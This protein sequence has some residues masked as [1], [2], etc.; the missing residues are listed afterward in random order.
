MA[1]RATWRAGEPVSTL[2]ELQADLGGALLGGPAGAAAAVVLEHGLGAEA[3]LAIYRHHVFATL[4]DVLKATYPVVCRLVDARFFAYAADQYIRRRP[5]TGPCLFEYGEG[6]GDFLATFPPCRDLPYLRDVARLEWAMNVAEH[7][8]DVVP[9]DDRGLRSVETADTPRLRFAF[10]PSL[11]LLESSWPIDR[12]WRANQP[13]VA[14]ST[15]D[16]AAG[17]VAL[18][19]RRAG[20]DVVFR[21]LEPAPWAFR[22]ALIA[23]RAL[24]TA[25]AAALGL[26]PGFDLA[27]AF[28]ALLADGVLAAFVLSPKETT[29]C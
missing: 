5:P 16:L 25:A 23:G 8:D 10:D 1:S 9:L 24:E 17:G 11:T 6:F 14:D 26:D 13:E 22:S 15:V 7:A 2:R 28:R 21:S 29:P 3:R 12:I 27:E 18:E 20:D 4:T 19:V